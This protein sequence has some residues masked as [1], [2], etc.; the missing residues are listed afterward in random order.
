[1]DKL[2]KYIK[3]R[4]MEEAQSLESELES[5]LDDDLKPA[6]GVKEDILRKI[7]HKMEIQ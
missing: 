6:E 5:E 4:Y 3:D 7:T 1:M 2:E